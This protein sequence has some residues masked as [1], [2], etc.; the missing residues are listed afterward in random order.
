M[1]LA[2][3]LDV[4]QRQRA[5]G[6]VAWVG[7]VLATLNQETVEVFVADYSLATNDGMSFVFNLLWYSAYGF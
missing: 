2:Y 4:F 6:E 3:F 5:G 7:I 1:P